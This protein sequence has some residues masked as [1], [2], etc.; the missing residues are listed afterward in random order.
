MRRYVIVGTGVAAVAAAE[1]IRQHDPRGV[2]VLVGMEAEGYYSR[3]GLAYYLTGEI[4]E[5]MLF[6]FRDADF[7]RLQV[8]VVHDR[9]EGLDPARQR[10]RLARR[11]W[12]AYDRLLLATGARAVRPPWPG[13]DL[14]GV[15]YLDNLAHTRHVIR[16]ARKAK[17]AVVVGGGITALELAEGLQ[18]RRVR[19]HYLLRG[20]R[21]WRRVLD[22]VESRLVE[23]R[24]T[25]MGIRLHHHTQIAEIL[26]HKGRVTGVRTQDGRVLRCQLVGIAVG[27]RPRVELAREA[28]IAT[29][30][31]IL[32]SPFMETSVPHVYAAGDVAQVFDPRVGQHVLDSLWPLARM[33]GTAA[34]ANMA[35]HRVPYHRGTPLNV[36]RLAHITTAIM[37]Q[38]GQRDADPD[39]GLVRGDS[40]VWRALPD[41]ILAQKNDEVNLIRLMVGRRTLLG[42]V[43]MGDQ[44]L[45]RGLY[46][47]IDRQVDITPIREQLLTP[48]APLGDLLAAFW[49]EVQAH[50]HDAAAENGSPPLR[51]ASE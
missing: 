2:I 4:P 9:V 6:P 41:A 13:V 22:P 25:Q 20:D 31:G 26:G 48:G 15:V 45:V 46:T 29:E 19:V 23:Q 28:G 35:G 47:L 34:G 30:R 32:V 51:E 36:T 17:E 11:G 24:L 40:E 1:A 18:A 7:R 44:S 8:Q 21:Y 42:A 27:I 10:V 37:G 39:A 50:I 3:P 33:Q 5:N 43:V 38:V 49:S 16:L 14:E 12:L